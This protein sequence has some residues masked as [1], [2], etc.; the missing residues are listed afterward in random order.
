M[1]KNT[2]TSKNKLAPYGTGDR[3][4]RTA[5]FKVTWHKNWDKNQNS[6]PDKL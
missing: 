2:K 1:L 4:L 5:N 3:L 6:G